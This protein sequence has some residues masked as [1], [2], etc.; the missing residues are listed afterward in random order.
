M[1]PLLAAGSEIG[2]LYVALFAVLLVVPRILQRFRLPAPLTSLALGAAAAHL[3]LLTGDAAVELLGTL[4]IVS[5]FLLAGIDVDLA[6]LRRDGRHL[7]QHLIVRTALILAFAVAGVALVDV[8]FQAA[9]V[10]AL[11]LLTPSAGFILEAIPGLGLFADERVAVRNRVIATELLSLGLLVVVMQAQSLQGIAT[12]LAA[13]AVMIAAVPL[14]LRWLA[15]AVAP[16]APGSEFAFLV[17]LAVGCAVLTKQIGVYYLVGAFAVGITA[18]RFRDRVPS[19]SSDRIVHGV[20]A[21]ASVFAP[22]YF[23]RAGTALRADDFS[24]AS[25]GAG[26]GLL[27][28]AC[29]AR[30]A[31]MLEHS[32]FTSSEGA[33]AALRK[34]IPMMPTLVFTLVLAEILRERFEVPEWLVGALVVY[35]VLNTLLPGF[36]VRRLA[37]P[38][39]GTTPLPPWPGSDA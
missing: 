37:V 32:R 22:F 30:V 1:S 21:F 5:I 23:F 18:R 38:D 15:H 33:L 14:V 9:V 19:M 39:A 4:G 34:A 17:V 6:L 7:F 35:A 27:V 16:H 12:S 13:I 36:L 26:V 20:E 8:T 3:G 28:I 11:A 31:S 10:L 25:L 24:L 29:G 2:A